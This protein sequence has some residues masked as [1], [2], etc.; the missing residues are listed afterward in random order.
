MASSPEPDSPIPCPVCHAKEI[1]VSHLDP[2]EVQDL[3]ITL[4][5][6]GEAISFK[7]A[8]ET[9]MQQHYPDLQKTSYRVPAAFFYDHKGDLD[10]ETNEDILTSRDCLRARGSAARSPTEV[11]IDRFQK[12]AVEKV[13]RRLHAWS[14][15]RGE[16]M[17]ILSEY[18]MQDYLRVATKSAKSK[19]RKKL[20][21]DHDVMVIHYESGVVVFVQ[22]KSV[23]ETSAWKTIRGKLKNAW[24]QAIKDEGAFRELNADM[25]DSISKV[26]VLRLVALPELSSSHLTSMGVCDSHRGSVLTKEIL[27]SASVFDNWIIEHLIRIKQ[28]KDST[29]F[30]LGTYTELCGRY[31][32]LASVVRIRT[33][34][35]AVKKASAKTGKILL[36]PEQKEIIAVGSKR[37][38]IMGEFGT[39]KSLVLAKM[40]EKIVGVQEG[41]CV[42]EEP[43]KNTVFIVSCTGVSHT[44]TMGRL[45]RSPCHLVAHLRNLIYDQSSSLK[46]MSVGGLFLY[47]YPELDP[48]HQRLDPTKMSELTRKIMSMHP[49]MQIHIM[50]DEVPFIPKWNW[51]PL[52]DLAEE[53]PETFIWVTIATGTYITMDSGSPTACVSQKIPSNFAV[54]HLKRCM[55][56]TRNG[57]NF[58]RALQEHLGDKGCSSTISGNAVHGGIP[59]WYSMPDCVCNTSEPLDCTC[60]QTR[61]TN[62][63]ERVWGLLKDINPSQVSIVVRDSEYQIDKFLFANVKQACR[64]LDIPE[65][66]SPSTDHPSIAP[67][68]TAPPN[69]FSR[70]PAF[71]SRAPFVSTRRSFL[72][73]VQTLTCVAILRSLR[74]IIVP[75]IQC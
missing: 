32:G 70:M 44:R 71:L 16:G 51:N 64:S 40:A 67:P 52:K 12:D 28:Q 43:K 46:I 27:Q 10:L 56:M 65:E 4:P 75:M 1:K 36:T 11:V 55:R 31:V 54:S 9:F 57:F 6:T 20:V 7:T 25:G 33:L 15:G 59:L 14:A 47:C 38:I 66:Q 72:N 41:D 42:D 34:P 69:I 58:Y 3:T 29:G 22:V 23:R 62:T 48:Y 61:L 68:F 74:P 21:G 73:V 37:Q 2:L 30:S 60:I 39:G 45:R 49:E 8:T 19:K 35:D 63:L 53:H 17:M 26:H 13:V 5:S 50:W 18:K 24:E